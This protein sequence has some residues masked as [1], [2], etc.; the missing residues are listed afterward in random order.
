MYASIGSNPIC[1][2]SKFI[3]IERGRFTESTV[4][5]ISTS[6]GRVCGIK[7]KTA[8]GFNWVGVKPLDTCIF[9][10]QYLLDCFNSIFITDNVIKIPSNLK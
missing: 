7:R 5:G 4:K 3:K 6:I 2:A 10:L 9:I 8:F 1:S